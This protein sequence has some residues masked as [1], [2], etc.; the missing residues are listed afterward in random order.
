MY[1]EK[2]G[3]LFYMDYGLA[4]V[5]VCYDIYIGFQND[6]LTVAKHKRPWFVDFPQTTYI[7][8]ANGLTFLT[9]VYIDPLPQHPM[10]MDIVSGISS[11]SQNQ[12]MSPTYSYTPNEKGMY[13]H[14]FF[15]P[16]LPP[17]QSK[18]C[19]LLPTALTP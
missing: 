11:M 5:W 2:K 12:C 15:I 13:P 14:L 7:A 16:S 19:S 4:T 6:M 1:N 8:A 3:I 18:P 17:I 10:Y 9:N